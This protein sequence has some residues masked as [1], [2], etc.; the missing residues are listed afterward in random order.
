MR[1][2]AR[3]RPARVWLLPLALTCAV[4]TVCVAP[5]PVEAQRPVAARKKRP[6]A[7]TPDANDLSALARFHA[8]LRDLEAGRRGEVAILQIGDSHTASD[9]VSGRL[10][11]LMQQRFGNAGRG[12]LPPGAPHAYYRPY[13][14]GVTQ[15]AGWTTLTS[16]KSAPE[17][18]PFGLSGQVA[19]ASAAGEAIAIDLRQEGRLRAFEVSVLRQPGGG[20]LEVLADGQMLATLETGGTEGGLESIRLGVAAGTR[21][22]ELRPFGD[23]PVDIADHTLIGRDRGVTLANVGFS[24]AQVGL[25]AKWDWPRTAAQIASIDPALIILAFGTNEGHAPVSGISARYAEQF[26]RQLTAL[27]SAALAASIVVIGPPD[28]NR[29]PKFCLP[30]PIL[31]P[32]ASDP[33]PEP[34]APAPTIGNGTAKAVT[35][36]KPPPPEPP[37]DAVCAPL[38]GPERLDYDAMLASQD[39]RLCRWHTPAAIP[40]VRAAQREIAARHGALF[41]DW[42]ELFEGECGADRW[43]RRGLA[44]KD[45]VH[46]KQDGYWQAADRLHGRLIAGYVSAK[47][48]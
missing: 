14:I 40:L 7:L 35:T 3:V 29:Y 27:K 4:T 30:K 39:R 31:P 46:F 22:I 45:R 34:T 24:G 10:R 20:S 17:P 12:F 41:F 44:H 16:N 47:P 1:D 33:A 18:V 42:F 32:A 23:G 13:Q 48:R 28:A 11:Q 9:H 38:D 6:A 2:R 25:L 37:E 19:R 21:R 8:R 26:E 5:G 43:F 36:V 15:T